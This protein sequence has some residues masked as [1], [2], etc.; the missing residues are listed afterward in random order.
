MGVKLLL[1]NGAYPFTNIKS[2]IDVENIV[3]VYRNQILI[4]T[5]SC[6]FI[7]DIIS[8]IKNIMIPKESNHKK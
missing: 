7:P 2:T 6:I 3:E 8:I 5:I 4:D 1:E